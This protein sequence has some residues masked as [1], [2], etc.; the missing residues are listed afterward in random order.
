MKRREFMTLLGG[1]AAWPLAAR[2]Q[3]PTMPAIG[4][5]GGGFQTPPHLRAAFHEGLKSFGYV[6]GKNVT[7]EYRRAEGRYERL[8]ALAAELAARQVAVMIA[9]GNINSPLAA[10]AATTTI[11]IVF[12]VGADPVHGGLVESLDRPGG[13]MTGVTV[14]GYALVGK[15][16]EMLHE[17][18]PSA[19]VFAELANRPGLQNLSALETLMRPLGV[20]VVGAN[21][22]TESEIDPA[23]ASLVEKQVEALGVAAAPL[24]FNKRDLLVASLTR[25][26]MPAIF[27]DKEAVAAGGLMSHGGNN[28]DAYRLLGTYVGRILKGE[29]PAELPVGIPKIDLVI[30]L[31][32][33]KAF[34]LTVPQSLIAKATELIE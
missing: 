4:W 19:K 26:K 14:F 7:T 3:Q 32:T 10:R 17:L 34:G 6:E 28:V 22:S 29:K 8:P 2:A 1:A 16:F 9:V 11:P 21:A 31:K 20:R 24:F 27:P 23:V 18:L 5:L 33:A 30:N 13:N 15:R 25:H 12:L